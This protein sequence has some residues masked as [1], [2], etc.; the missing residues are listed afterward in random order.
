MSHHRVR[1]DNGHFNYCRSVKYS[2]QKHCSCFVPNSRINRCAFIRPDIKTVI[3]G[4]LLCMCSWHADF[5]CIAAMPPKT[6][7][8][9]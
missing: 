2:D 8:G 9:V 6:E 5:S 1:D 7:S 3:G 4:H